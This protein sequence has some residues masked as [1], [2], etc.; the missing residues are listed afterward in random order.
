MRI[1]ILGTGR[2][3]AAM[4]QGWVSAG[5]DPASITCSP[6]NRQVAARLAAEFG[7]VAAASDADAV[8]RADVVILSVPPAAAEEVLASLSFRPTQRVVSVAAG[9]PLHAL[10]PAARPAGIARA[11]P[12]TAAAVGVTPI[13][14]LGGDGMVEEV[15]SVLGTLVPVAD[16]AAFEV[17][18]VSL[19]TYAW[20]LDLLGR[21]AVWS[22]RNG[23][24]PEA[25]RVLAAETFAAAGRMVADLP[26]RP[27]HDIAKEA[28]APGGLA[29]AGLA[30]LA[31][32]GVNEAWAAAHDE[33]LRRGRGGRG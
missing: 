10:G 13:P 15:L 29:A 4:V 6:R 28:A 20:V 25:S 19:S 3:A 30:R 7:V 33:A 32:A 27:V 12:T 31:G 11:M 22:F 18:C 16:E 21:S 26:E 14:I 9:V 2:I 23:L 17:A 5:I 1:G 8:D 24:D